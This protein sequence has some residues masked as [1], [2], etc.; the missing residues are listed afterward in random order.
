[1]QWNPR[2]ARD[3]RV[4]EQGGWLPPRHIEEG[5]PESAGVFVFAG[6]D[7]RVTYVGRALEG[8][9]RDEAA[10]ARDSGKAHGATMVTWLATGSGL[11]ARTLAR[12]LVFKYRPRENRRGAA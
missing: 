11:P 3:R 7:R 1:M 10:A 2:D 6:L 8:R 5:F 12:D 4:A 9:L